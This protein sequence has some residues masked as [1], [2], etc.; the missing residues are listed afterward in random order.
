MIPSASV[1]KFSVYTPNNNNK[2]RNYRTKTKKQN[3]KKINENE[4]SP[5]N[6][7]SGFERVIVPTSASCTVGGRSR[8][9]GTPAR[10]THRPSSRLSRNRSRVRG[11]TKACLCAFEHRRIRLRLP[12]P[13]GSC[14]PMRRDESFFFKCV[15]ISHGQGE[16]HF[17]FPGLDRRCLSRP[18]ILPPPPHPGR[19]APLSAAAA[20]AARQPRARLALAARRLHSTSRLSRSAR[21]SRTCGEGAGLAKLGDSK[22]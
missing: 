7:R 8:A 19:R 14:S 22:F 9:R 2:K 5:I 11:L 10:V 20:A 12:P 13:P 4:M 3:T 1:H 16:F 18:L 21:R 17:S 15:Y 6:W